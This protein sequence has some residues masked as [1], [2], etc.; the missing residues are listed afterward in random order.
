M[1]SDNSPR[2]RLSEEELTLWGRITR[3]VMPL[4]RRPLLA[5][6]GETV[7]ASTKAKA[8]PSARTLHATRSATTVSKPVPK[9]APSLEPLGRRQKQ[10]LARGTLDIEARIDLH[11]K[12]QSQAHAALLRFL[13]AAQR[14]GAKFVLVITGKGARAQDEHGERGVLKRQVPL[15]LKLPEFRAYVVGFEDAHIGHGGEGA[16]YL[17]LRRARA[18]R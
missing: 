1:S 17:R 8:V 11:G 16:L 9:P 12:T 10:R 13:Q 6:S 14:D 7:A 2:R 3:S 4:R 15:W 5:E 18:G